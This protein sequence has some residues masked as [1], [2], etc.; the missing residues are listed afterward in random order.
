MQSFFQFVVDDL[1]E[2]GVVEESLRYNR[3]YKKCLQKCYTKDN[4]FYIAYT[5]DIV[6]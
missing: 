5:I 2:L 1:G 3:M 4:I 6:A